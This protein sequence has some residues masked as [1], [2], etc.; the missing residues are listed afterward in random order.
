MS[1]L[2]DSDIAYH[3]YYGDLEVEPVD[4]NEQLQP[5]S[6]D[7]RLGDTIEKVCGSGT[8]RPIIDVT[9]DEVPT[10]EISSPKINPREF[11]LANTKEIFEIPD[12]LGCEVRGRSSLARMGIEIHSTAGWVDPGFEGELV[13]EIS[14]NSRNI[15]ELEEGMRVGQLVFY[16]L[17]SPSNNPYNSEDNKYQG[18][19]GAQGSRLHEEL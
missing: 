13:L 15:I 17:S 18:Q 19:E 4:L 8:G 7:I 1:V 10:D 6:L 11:Y 14:N 16:E 5:A 3:L 9:E 2:S 12:Y